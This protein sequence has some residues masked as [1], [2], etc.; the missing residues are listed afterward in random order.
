MDGLA[1]MRFASRAE[2]CGGW[3]CQAIERQT[4]SLSFE[5]RSRLGDVRLPP[6]IAPAAGSDLRLRKQILCTR[7]GGLAAGVP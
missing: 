4:H 3:G 2:P 1:P 7:C 5:R 6:A